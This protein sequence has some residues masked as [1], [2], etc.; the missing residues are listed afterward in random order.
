MFL[1]ILF[2]L[3]V[4]MVELGKIYYTYYTLEKIL[5]NLA[6]YVSI[7]QG[8]NFCD[9]ADP[10]VTAAINYA[11]TG[12]GDGSGA[13]VLPGLTAD[14]ILV[15]PERFSAATTSLGQCDCS[16]TGCDI[17]QGALQPDFIEVS[18]PNG[19]LIQPGIPGLRIDPIPL[20]P[21]V[22]VPFEGS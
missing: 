21:H 20:K 15:Q 4:G 12:T 9:A 17:S 14:M 22:L 10:V 11:L 13:P 7:Q 19:Y 18:L 6:R 8:A 5:Y 2:L 3:L 16:A 1:P